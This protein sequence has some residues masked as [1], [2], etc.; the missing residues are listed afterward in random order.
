MRA[1]GSKS[2]ISWMAPA[3]LLLGSLVFFWPLLTGAHLVPFHVL[4]GD[5]ALEGIDLSADRPAWRFF[6]LSP[7]TMFYAEKGL[8]ARLLRSGQLPL[9]NPY[10]GLGVPLLADSISQPLAP[11]FLPFLFRPTPWVYSLC[12]VLQVLW[13]GAGMLLFLRRIGLGAAA[14]TFG[15]LLFSFGPF[16]LNFCGYSDVWACMWF[17]WVLFALEGA[18]SSAHSGALAALLVAL[19]GMSGHIEVAFFIAVLAFAYWAVRRWR[20]GSRARS[21]SLLLV[22]SLGGFG[23]SAWWVFP[24]V[25]YL[26]H[27]WSPRFAANTPFPYHPSACLIPG[28]EIYWSPVLVLLATA[29]WCVRRNR[30]I[31]LAVL[32]A[33]LW[34]VAMMFPWPE[35]VQRAATL[36]FASGRYGRGL[37]WTGLIVWATLGVDGLA[38]GEVGRRG[39][40]ASVVAAVA[41]WVAGFMVAQPSVE[42]LLSGKF[43]PLTGGT[44]PLLGWMTALGLLAV[45][46]AAFGAGRRVASVTLA[47]AL[48]SLA[49]ASE[50]FVHP[51]LDLSWNRSEPCLAAVV[52]HRAS[53]EPGRMW[54]PDRDLWRSLPPNLSALWGIWDVRYCAP[55]VPG[56]LALLDPGRT[57]FKDLFGSWEPERASFLG[58]TTAWRL[59]KEE[60]GLVPSEAM[61][62][63]GR[64]FWVG[65]AE[66][67]S[68]PSE[69]ATRALKGGAWR[70]TVFLEGPISGGADRADVEARGAVRPLEDEATASRWRVESPRQ[71]WLVLRDLYYPG[72]KGFLD[73]RPA[74]L[75]TA[76]GVFRAVRL[77]AGAHEVA[78]RYHPFSLFFGTALTLLTIVGLVVFWSVRRFPHRGGDR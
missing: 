42:K 36:D 8:C 50:V 70:S 10:N 56:G 58:V 47:V 21:R 44:A 25:E 54:F 33:V 40:W 39:R 32:P 68:S 71:G 12:L 16:T 4:A 26:V 72:W 73:G 22:L 62:Q 66:P 18:A 48:A 7:V 37:V 52:S 55:I 49:L 9:W 14:Q 27:S 20:E 38:R 17:P 29:G 78:F 76:D 23:L 46:L 69:G 13:G 11:F 5:P 35:W 59:G 31:A 6:D 15:A 1:P 24:F 41:W 60:D 57:P 74:P 19:M 28:S 63:R 53:R 34:G 2:W 77:E 61:G 3:A 64:A 30:G 51:V 43:V 67:V 65:R 75:Y 45:L